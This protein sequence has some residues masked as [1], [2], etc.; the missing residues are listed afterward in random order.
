LNQDDLA[1]LVGARRE[2]INRL[3]Q[4]WQRQGWMEYKAGKIFIHDL[5]RM[6]QERDRRLEGDSMDRQQEN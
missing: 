3:L 2:W 6:R 5:A 1:S 4:T